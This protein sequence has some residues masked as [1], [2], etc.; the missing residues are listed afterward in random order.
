MGEH[1][2]RIL[3]NGPPSYH[4]LLRKG[5]EP[6]KGTKKP[7][8]LAAGAGWAGTAEAFKLTVHVSSSWEESREKAK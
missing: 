4:L 6:G 1:I 5:V 3:T 7:L 8:R 2:L